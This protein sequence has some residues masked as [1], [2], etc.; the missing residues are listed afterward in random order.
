MIYNKNRE[1]NPRMDPRRMQS[2]WQERRNQAWRFYCPHCRMQ[3]ALP[4]KPQPGTRQAVQITLT[5]AFSTLLT[6]PLLGFKGVVAFIPIWMAFEFFYRTRSRVALA[7]VRCGFDP[8]L[9]LT[10]VKK[11]RTQIEETIKRHQSKTLE[12]P[13]PEMVSEPIESNE[14]PDLEVTG[15]A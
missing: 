11:A 4:Y 10:D 13:L 7:C 12:E 15:Q 1:G 5:T 9:Y 3:R 6:W 14:N 2:L 8:F